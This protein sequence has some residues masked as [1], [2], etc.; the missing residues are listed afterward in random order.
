MV[1]AVPLEVL[2]VGWGYTLLRRSAVGGLAPPEAQVRR[3]KRLGAHQ[4]ETNTK[5]HALEPP[6]THQP[7]PWRPHGDFERKR[8]RRENQRERR[9][10]ILRNKQINK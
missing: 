6:Q 3:G 1:V 4:A 10:L 8:N 7:N 9:R 5:I 2:V